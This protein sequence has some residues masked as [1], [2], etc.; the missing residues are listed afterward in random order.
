VNIIQV[1]SGSVMLFQASSCY[2]SLLRLLEVM[3]GKLTL[4]QLRSGRSD[5]IR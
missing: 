3:S 4:C 5:Y 2:T 1:M